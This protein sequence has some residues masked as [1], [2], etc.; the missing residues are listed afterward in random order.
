MY[1]PY[2][3]QFQPDSAAAILAL[4]SETLSLAHNALI[5]E[6]AFIQVTPLHDAS[7]MAVNI[8]PDAY[9]KL[10]SEFDIDED[11]ISFH[12]K[13]HKGDYI[14]ELNQTTRLSSQEAADIIAL[15]LT[16]FRDIQQPV[17]VFCRGADFDPPRLR[18]FMK[19]HGYDL[20][21]YIHYRNFRDL[22]SQECIFPVKIGS[23]NHTALS[24]AYVVQRQL[25]M[26]ASRYPAFAEYL[27]GG[28]DV[29][30]F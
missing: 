7:N 4:D 3:K 5:T 8:S 30:N 11:T 21:E 19:V 29:N 18:Y 22:R 13:N 17:V 14:W 10:I 15:H 27:Y 12:N 28:P 25:Q 23:G 1:N 24:D 16:Q 2:T 6:V 26:M 9:G 20:N